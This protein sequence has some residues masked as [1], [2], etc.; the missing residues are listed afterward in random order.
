[1]AERL[2]EQVA[3]TTQTVTAM[4]HSLDQAVK[5][6]QGE[7]ASTAKRLEANVNEMQTQ[8]IAHIGQKA[9]GSELCLH[10]LPPLIS[11]C[12]GRFPILSNVSQLDLSGMKLEP[13]AGG[14]VAAYISSNVSSFGTNLSW[15]N[16]CC[17]WIFL[18]YHHQGSIDIPQPHEQQSRH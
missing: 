13:E 10:L 1:M 17:S 7:T 16:C 4:R 5:Q 12:K 11:R 2:E 3:E 15:F 18:L 6:L 14:L 8:L 9:N